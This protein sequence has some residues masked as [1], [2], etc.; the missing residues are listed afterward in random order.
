MLDNKELQRIRDVILGVSGGVA[1]DMNSTVY[2]QQIRD[3]ILSVAPAQVM[4]NLAEKIYLQQIRDA[5][6]GV[7]DGQFGNL[8]N[9][10]YLQQIL[11]AFNSVPD[12][13]FGSQSDHLYLDEITLVA[14][15]N[16]LLRDDFLTNRSAGGVNGTA[17]EPGP[18]TRKVTDAENKITIAS[19]SLVCSGGKAAPAYGDPGFW[20]NNNIARIAGRALSAFLKITDVTAGVELGWD[21]TGAAGALGQDAFRIVSDAVYPYQNGTAGPV[22]PY[23]PA[24][25][26]FLGYAVVLRPNGAYYMIHD[27]SDW[28]LWWFNFGLPIANN[29]VR[30]GI[31]NFTAAW[32]TN[33]SKFKVVSGVIVTP[34][35][36][37]TFHR[38]DGALGVSD[39]L[40]LAEGGGSGKAWSGA[41]WAISSNKAVATPTLG[42]EKLSDPGLEAAYTAGLCASLTKT[43]APTL[44]QSASVHG[45]AKAQQFTA[46][47]QWDRLDSADFTP[48]VGT[49]YEVSGWAKRTAGSKG[50]THFGY[51][52]AVVGGNTR[53][54]LSAVYEHIRFQF[55]ATTTNVVNIY[56]PQERGA[57]S[58]WDTVITDD[59]SIKPMV[60]TDMM[61]NV[62]DLGHADTIGKVNLT[63]PNIGNWAGVMLNADS[64]VNPQ[65]YLL[66]L[67]GWDTTTVR[68]YQ[69]LA[70]VPTV[71]TS[72]T[73]AFSADGSNKTGC[74]L[75]WVKSGNKIAIYLNEVIMGT[76]QTVHAN[77]TNNTNFAAFSTDPL[78]TLENLVVLP[79]VNGH[80]PTVPTSKSVSGHLVLC[81]GDSLTA[82]AGQSIWHKKYPTQLRSLLGAGHIVH[83]MGVGGQ[84][85]DTLAA[86]IAA[87]IAGLTYGGD[88]TLVVWIGSNDIQA[89]TAEADV[90]TDISTI[91][92]AGQAAGFRVLVLNIIKRGNIVGGNET[93]RT[94]L[95]VLIAANTAGAD[96]LVDLDANAAF[97]N[98][99]DTTYYDA[100]TIHLNATGYGIVAGLVN[101]AI[102]ALP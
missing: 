67:Y 36:S 60:I 17:A 52:Y 89:G 10:I 102:A 70:G 38:A 86:G 94:E 61:A 49:W 2:L 56:S 48:V 32:T 9:E 13:T 45:G 65:N 34:L 78:N 26:V 57:T 51:G 84:T 55:F 35:L 12:G 76:V 22:L 11:N 30:P 18:G 47:A 4:G 63:V 3:A 64:L 28:R 25:N 40:V 59:L 21:D 80:D 96:G 72:G 85:A 20:L 71:L 79:V 66:A 54:I 43:G 77:I 58:G 75:K 99:A 100:D 42:V 69:V 53:A 82:N 83:N 73:P 37:D 44:V 91:V 74:E 62:G 7:P 31:A 90:Y 1:G 101:T 6:L 95:N 98:A 14:R 27:G 93:N 39:G 29:P 24:D 68:L 41:A 87:S 97:S 88:K 8:P 81:V 23:T 5:I 15:A 16:Y 92:T 19:E 46:T 33:K 50:A